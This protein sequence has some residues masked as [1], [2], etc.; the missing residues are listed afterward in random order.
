MDG[1]SE[2][3]RVVARHLFCESW[4]GLSRLPTSF[5]RRRSRKDV[6]VRDNRG[7]GDAKVM[8][9]PRDAR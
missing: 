9:S 1:C 7:H 5:L 3:D 6:D 4:P 8:R 2:R